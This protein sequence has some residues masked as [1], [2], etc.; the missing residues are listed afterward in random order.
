MT[1]EHIYMENI[2]TLN[3]DSHIRN[4]RQCGGGSVMVW[5]MVMPNNLLS[6]SIISCKFCSED[7]IKLLEDKALPIIMLNFGNNLIFQQ[8]NASVHC[9]KLLQSFFEK[10]KISVLSWPAKSPDLNITED[11][12]EAYI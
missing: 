6:F 3:S 8:D 4:K 10:S 9:S 5:M 2:Y 1:G 7:N 12:L 11:A